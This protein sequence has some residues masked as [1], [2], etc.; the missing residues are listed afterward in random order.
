MSEEEAKRREAIARLVLAL[1]YIAVMAWYLIPEHQ[2]KLT[3]MRLAAASRRLCERAALRAGHQSMTLELGTGQ[4][5]YE[6]P[7]LLS[8]ARDRAARFY[9]RLRDVTP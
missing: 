9:D 3:G 2:R 8:L 7:Y 6:L 1:A 4:R 5:R